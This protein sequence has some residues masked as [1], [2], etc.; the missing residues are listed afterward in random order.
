MYGLYQQK[1]YYYYCIPLPFCPHIYE[2][3]AQH[4]F[5]GEENCLHSNL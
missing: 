5:L 3:Q 2:F 1:F 4:N